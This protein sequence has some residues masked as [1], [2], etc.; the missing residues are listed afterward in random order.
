MINAEN[1]ICC[2][3]DENG[4]ELTADDVFEE[5]TTYTLELRLK[6][7]NEN[8]ADDKSF[9][10]PHTI[11]TVNDEYTAEYL[12]QY[13]EYQVFALDFYIPKSEPEYKLGD[14]NA[15]GSIDFKDAMLSIKYAKKGAAPKDDDQFKRADVNNDGVLDTKD[16]MILIKA[17]KKLITIG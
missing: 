7:D 8:A 6:R 13:G 15:D 12:R 5:D 9:I 1:G 3:Y 16:S 10:T 2:W 4:N 14:I 11:V 17:A